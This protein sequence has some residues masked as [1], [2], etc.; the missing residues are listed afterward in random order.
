MLM[1]GEL[2]LVYL[3]LFPLGGVKAGYLLALFSQSLL[4]GLNVKQILI[5]RWQNLRTMLFRVKHIYNL[6]LSLIL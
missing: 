2:S 4:F 1:P 5:Q 6:L 3:F